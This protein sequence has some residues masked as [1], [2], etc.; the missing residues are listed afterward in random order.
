[1]G[2]TGVNIKT[3]GG[4][5]RTN[6]DQIHIQ[7]DF[8][9]RDGIV[10]KYGE[11]RVGDFQDVLDILSDIEDVD[12]EG[13]YFDERISELYDD[14]AWTIVQSFTACW[15][16][17]IESIGTDEWAK[18]IAFCHGRCFARNGKMIRTYRN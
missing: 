17:E 18:A 2:I 6:P 15:N 13:R 16:E 8:N 5:P 9:P 12:P 3:D 1:M 11:H 4:I 14:L 10:R 7:E